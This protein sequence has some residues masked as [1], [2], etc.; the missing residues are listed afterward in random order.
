MYKCRMELR[1][2]RYFV[3]VAEELSFSRAARRLHMTQP[4]LSAQVRQLE[5]EIGVP[6]FERSTRS[7]RL[8]EAGQLL[9]DE[10]RRLLALL[11]QNVRMVRRV[12]HGEVGRL[13]LGFVPSAS[14]NT[15]PPLLRVFRERFPDVELSLHEMNPREL[16]R[17]LH[18]G[19][20][21]AAFFYLPH[22]AAPPFGDALLDS[23]P[24]LR[25]AL[26]VALP[27]GHALAD[28]PEVGMRALADEPFVLV[29]AHQ[30]TGLR[31]R[32]VELC[33]QDGY[34]PRVAQEAY[35]VQTVVGLVGSGVGISLV[36]ASLRNLQTV[37]VVYRPLRD[38]VPTVDMGIVWRRDDSGVVLKEFLKVAAESF[39][40]CGTPNREE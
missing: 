33:R 40:G 18:D 6:L 24:V 3:A 16:V 4:P 26:V 19:R 14:N 12:G 7:V 23:R 20:I 36:P 39:D 22:G 38:A 31:D 2:L 8:T 10:T 30:G 13:T 1:H 27:E 37:G 32:I 9:L 25:E 35:L 15:L 28:E 5:E 17:A 29:A 11:E 34:E 21:D